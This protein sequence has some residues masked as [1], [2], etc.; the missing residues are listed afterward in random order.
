MK[1]RREG[2]VRLVVTVLETGA[3]GAVQV[4]AS[5]G[6]DLDAAAVAAVRQFRYRPATVDGQ[7]VEAKI[8]VAYPFRL[9]RQAPRESSRPGEPVRASAG[10]KP[11]GVRP[12]RAGARR[13]PSE[14]AELRGRLR[15]RGTRA[16]LRDGEVV[17]L[18]LGK[19]AT[20]GSSQAAVGGA[21]AAREFAEEDGRFAMRLPPGRYRVEVR[22]PG[23][24]PFTVTE[25]L[26]PGTRLEVEYFVERRSYDPYET[27]VT[28]QAERKEVTRHSI[29]LAVVEK[30]PGTQGDALRAVQNMPGVGRAPF[31]LGFLIIRG[32]APKDTRVFL[33]GHSIPSLYHFMGLASV[34][35]SDLLS[36]ID[37]IPG[38]FSVAY[39]R[40]T[41]GIVDVATRS[42]RSDRWHGAVSA[43]VWGLAALAEGPVGKGSLALSIRRSHIDA[44][45]AMIP[46]IALTAAYYDYALVFE[47][48]LGGGTL[49][50]IGFG[51]DDR[52]KRRVEDSSR[53]ET[54][55]VSLFAKLLAMY[56][57]RLGDTAFKASVAGGYERQETGVNAR[58]GAVQDTG[59]VS[60]RAQVEHLAAK[61]LKLTLGLDGE[62]A[63]HKI[64]TAGSG[65]SL[66]L[67][68][69]DDV[70][71]DAAIES[72]VA[73]GTSVA[74]ALFA[75]AAWSPTK[76]FTLTP[77]LRV[78]WFSEETFRGISFDPRLT[79][80]LVVL[81]KKLTLVAAIGLF[82]Q[83]P[84]LE[85]R[86]TMLLGSPKLWFERALH[87][88]LG[89][90][91]RIRRSLSLEVTAFHKQLW[92]LVA[93]SEEFVYRDGKVVPEHHASTGLGRVVGGE[94]L[95]QKRPGSDC[96]R[97][98]KLEKCFGWVSYTALRSE[99]R[100]DRGSPW[101]IF[102]DD[103]THLFTLLVQG[104]WPGGWE[105][106]LRFRLASGTPAEF[107]KGGVFSGDQMSYIPAS[108]TLVKGRMPMFH[109]LDIRLDKRFAFKRWMLCLYLDIQNVYSYQHSEFLQYNF[110]YTR[111]GVLKGLPIVPS[112]GL[113][114]EL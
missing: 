88:S 7:P 29:P 68:G 42:P 34:F 83:E 80:R 107:Y 24:F 74:S 12:P 32:A 63:R 5:A 15:E 91:W 64:S 72:Q 60:Y 3:V 89:F 95:L 76:R 16:A 13:A 20:S 73:R 103:Q 85:E 30:I 2:V 61:G 18:R 17:A 58:A 22:A 66:D 44:I 1:E 57:R 8:R 101:E 81:P 70:D 65:L 27:V 102:E 87:S 23:C 94:L 33:D 55:H 53:F 28:V 77:G 36:R 31:S 25:V 114:G 52:L 41:G 10:D 45:L 19:E 78:D 110:D 69:N 90:G 54:V 92:N 98:L 49:K 43:D 59:S 106:G 100:T 96:P 47:H 38:N 111:R 4:E 6:Q 50:L 35:N 37:F 26:G 105:L 86:H 112:L 109:Q 104:A 39:G 9:P 48:P 82:H 14:Q 51:A 79:A 67:L 46:D 56:S 21:A 11:S 62:V 40:A 97:W 75:E 84:E 108:G 71:E 99:R 93:D 113:K